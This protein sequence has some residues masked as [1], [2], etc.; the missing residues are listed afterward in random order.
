M[1]AKI[2]SNTLALVVAFFSIT[3]SVFNFWLQWKRQSGEE[4]E[5]RRNILRRIMGYAYRLT[6]GAE[7]L[8]GEPFAALNEA[9]VVFSKFPKVKDQLIKFH[10]ESDSPD[11]FTANYLGL[12]KEMANCSKVS[13]DLTDSRIL[14]DPFGP[15]KLANFPRPKGNAGQTSRYETTSQ[16][17]QKSGIPK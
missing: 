7:I 6:E 15:K 9:L 11:K 10:Q 13:I 16:H 2:D 12:I 8:D 5:L 4:V 3:I 1:V 17:Q 14:D